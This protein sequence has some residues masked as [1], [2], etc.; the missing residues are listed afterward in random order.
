MCGMTIL[1]D[2]YATRKIISARY[3]ATLVVFSLLALMI[4]QPT[5]AQSVT[6]NDEMLLSKQDAQLMFSFSRD[7]WNANVSAAV[8]KGMAKATGLPESG[9]GMATPHDNGF[10]IVRPDFSSGAEPDFIQVIVGYRA[11]M[12]SLLSLETLQSMAVK[13]K[14]ELAPEYNVNANVERVANGKV[15]FFIITR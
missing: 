13:A 15:I 10:M 6:P 1:H 9:L 11:P 12:A 5:S 7:Q 2:I 3:L 8:S 4:A 14:A